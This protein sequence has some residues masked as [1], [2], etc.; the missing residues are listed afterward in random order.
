MYINI[1]SP[2]CTP[3]NQYILFVD[4]FSIF[5]KKEEIKVK[6]T[7][8]YFHCVRIINQRKKKIDEKFFSVESL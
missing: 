8:G 7:M 1:E 4:E 6:A 2:G 3:E 5:G